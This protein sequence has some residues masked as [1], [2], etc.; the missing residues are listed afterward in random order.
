MDCERVKEV[1]PMPMHIDLTL[2][3]FLSATM[4]QKTYRTNSKQV[5]IVVKVSEQIT[6][7]SLVLVFKLILLYDLHDNI[8][9]INCLCQS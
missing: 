8:K 4:E 2:I 6:S 7:F 9:I 3:I 5:N 1:N